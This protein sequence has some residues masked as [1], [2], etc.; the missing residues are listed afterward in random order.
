MT[1]FWNEKSRMRTPDN[2]PSVVPALKSRPLS[3]THKVGSF[4]ASIKGGSSPPKEVAHKSE[5]LEYSQQN[6]KPVSSKSVD[7][8][9]DNTQHSQRLGSTKKESRSLSTLSATST[10]DRVKNGE[11]RGLCLD[12]TDRNHWNEP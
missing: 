4:V 5:E 9:E 7:V 3:D 11:E 6:T 12:T 8:R 1:K 10:H 2:A